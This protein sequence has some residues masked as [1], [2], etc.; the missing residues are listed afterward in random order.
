ML[1]KHTFAPIQVPDV[2]Q[3]VR[4]RDPVNDQ[5]VLAVRAENRVSVP[6]FH[7]GTMYSKQLLVVIHA[8]NH[9]LSAHRRLAEQLAHGVALELAITREGHHD[10]DLALPEYAQVGQAQGGDGLIAQ[11]GQTGAALGMVAE[12]AGCRGQPF[13]AGK[14]LAREPGALEG[15]T[16]GLERL[17]Q[18]QPALSL[19]PLGCASRSVAV[20]S[21]FNAQSRFAWVL[22]CSMSSM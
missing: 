20:F 13:Q 16:L 8:A 6:E 18:L 7:F 14:P 4:A 19:G 3:A 12:L 1:M 22:P 2:D 10:A 21:A 11:L 15:R 9:K 5:Q 17:T